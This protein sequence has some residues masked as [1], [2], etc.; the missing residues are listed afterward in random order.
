M[1]KSKKKEQQTEEPQREA[2][3]FGI[4]EQT[5]HQLQEFL[6]M[7]PHGQVKGIHAGLQRGIWYT[8]KVAEEQ[9]VGE[10]KS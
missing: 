7:C 8:V 9:E 5:Y 6:D 1:S 3:V 2:K 10:K 4:P